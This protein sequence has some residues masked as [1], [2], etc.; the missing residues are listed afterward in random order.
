MTPQLATNASK[1]A[2]E[3]NQL[4]LMNNV[5]TFTLARLEREIDKLLQRDAFNAYVLRGALAGL[6]HDLQAIHESYRTA[7]K[8]AIIK[9][10]RVTVFSNYASALEWNGYFSEAVK[11]AMESYKV[12]PSAYLLQRSIELALKTGLFHQAADLIRKHPDEQIDGS[13]AYF[14]TEQFMDEHAVSDELLQKLIEIAIAV[15]HKC[16]FFNF[17]RD[18]MIRP[19]YDKDEDSQLFYYIITVNRSMEE[20]IDMNYELA[21]EIAKSGLPTTL[22]LN[23]IPVYEVA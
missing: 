9:E 20:V 7:L 11:L 23:F 22:T 14:Q 6:K 18:G 5:D 16:G 10:D 1:L 17:H 19:E 2:D 15:L 4:L 12:F 13:H 21:C 3:I 8:L